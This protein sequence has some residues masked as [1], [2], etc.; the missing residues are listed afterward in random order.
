MTD[1]TDGGSKWQKHD[2]EPAGDEQRIIGTH[3]S[4]KL[5]GLNG[6]TKEMDIVKHMI[7]KSNSQYITKLHSCNHALIHAPTDRSGWEFKR[8]LVG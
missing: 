1:G 3:L 7:F 2:P 5:T 6:G 4:E 8:K